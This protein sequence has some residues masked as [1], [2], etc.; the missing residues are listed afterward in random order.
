MLNE[1]V[2]ELIFVAVSI[3]IVLAGLL[4]G[5]K[6]VGIVGRGI[7]NRFA[8]RIKLP[9]VIALSESLQCLIV[10]A[11][12]SLHK[13]QEWQGKVGVLFSGFVNPLLQWHYLRRVKQLRY[14]TSYSHKPLLDT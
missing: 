12:I 8:Q 14:F 1:A 13:Q 11:T 9:L 7:K 5:G 6:N 3:I 2:D 10:V 4:L